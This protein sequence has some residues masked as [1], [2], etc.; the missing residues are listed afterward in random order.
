MATD[1]GWGHAG[2]STKRRVRAALEWSEFNIYI[3][4]FDSKERSSVGGVLVQVHR[5][6]AH[7]EAV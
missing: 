5:N 6:A 2:E 1:C 3:Y 4:V 7:S